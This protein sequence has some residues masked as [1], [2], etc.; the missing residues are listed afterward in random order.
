MTQP[1]DELKLAATE[2]A[3][4]L[5][6]REG[7]QILRQIK[8]LLRAT[9]IEPLNSPSKDQI[10]GMKEEVAGVGI[11]EPQQKKGKGFFV[12]KPRPDEPATLWA[13]AHSISPKGRRR[14]IV[15][16]GESVARGFFFDPYFNPKMVLEQILRRASASDDVEVVDLART[17]LL[18]EPLRELAKAS[19]KLEPDAVVVLAGNN[20]SPLLD[21]RPQHLEELAHKL[22]S[23]G[24]WVDVKLYLEKLLH[25]R[26]LSLLETLVPLAQ[27][28][29]FSLIMVIPEFNL[30]DWRTD[31]SGPPLLTSRDTAE[32]HRTR[33][34]AEQAFAERNIE[35]AKSLGKRILELDKCTTPVGANIIADVNL[36]SGYHEE[37]TK[38]LEIA[39][40]AA[41]CWA[42]SESPRCYSIIQE[43][44]RSKSTANGFILVDLP[45][46][47]RAHT[48]NH[49]ADRRLFLD[50]CHFTV[51]GTHLAMT[52]V[53]QVVLS[54]LFRI[55]REFSE[56]ARIRIVVDRKVEGEAHFLAAIHNA[57]WGQSSD[58][59]RYH[60]MR[61]VH[62]FPG[63]DRMM[64]C[65]LEFHVRRAPSA[66][67]KA[68]D[69][70]CQLDSLSAVSLLFN[71]STPIG[72]NF[73]NWR[74]MHAIGEAMQ[75]NNSERKCDIERLLYQEHAVNDGQ[76][77]LLRKAYALSSFV[78]PFDQDRYAYYKVHDSSSTFTVVC[79]EVEPIC[80]TITYRSC[81]CG[82][83]A[84][85][86]LLMNGVLVVALPC[87]QSWSTVKI[88]VPAQVIRS[89]PN[90]LDIRWP[91][92]EWDESEKID[93]VTT[94]LESGMFADL[95][96]LYGAIGRLE[97]SLTMPS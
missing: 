57:N 26:V 83:E 59:V 73:L 42:R 40:D 16:L 48:N 55:Q 67:C 90:C 94:L 17:D 31:T 39:R 78:I 35:K 56:L 2:L 58:V 29:R 91:M 79:K 86:N 7:K 8:H 97:A 52:S 89:G 27:S 74:L 11:W 1:S 85:V 65:F 23:G 54:T 84:L 32:W 13:S 69:D 30:V 5:S 81:R 51:D 77:D 6:S 28:H 34:E 15:L 63:I 44:L 93:K 88:M 18:L 75:G 36:L 21:L 9:A 38:Y 24:K 41:I 45:R 50:Y 70:L 4:G 66:L 62:L 10:N 60:C 96:P 95:R 80:L 72:E 92:P 71:P 82:S 46:I 87:V 12:R 37:A 76:L 19:V 49:L 22:L 25:S 53:A 64:N 47:F 3:R 14:R 20:W 33:A 43:T 61:A 68:F